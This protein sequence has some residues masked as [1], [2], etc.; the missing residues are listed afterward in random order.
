MPFGRRLTGI[1]LFL[2]ARTLLFTYRIRVFGVDARQSAEAAH[3]QKAFCLALWHDQLFGSILAHAGQKIAPLASLSK[4]GD[5]VSFVMN[6]LGYKPVRGSSSRR[7]EEARDELVDAAD[8]GYITAITVDGPRGPKR[9]VKG[10]VIDVARRTG[11]SI[12]PLITTADRQWVLRRSWDQTK[13]PK[14]FARVAVRY[15]TPVPVP[16][17]TQGLAFGAAKQAVKAS[18]DRAEALALE[19]LAQWR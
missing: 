19:D 7:G 4:D 12:L 10:G 1:A 8:H 9:R 18:L 6:W 16:Q 5:L 13:I 14:P 17:G 3:A 2:V 11:I 15:G